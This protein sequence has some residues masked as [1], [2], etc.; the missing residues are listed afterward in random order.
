MVT[1]MSTSENFLEEYLPRATIEILPP[2][3]C[4]NFYLPDSRR[5]VTSVHQGLSQ[6]GAGEEPG[7][8]V[9][10]IVALLLRCLSATSGKKC[11]CKMR[12]YF[13]PVTLPLTIASGPTPS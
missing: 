1:E 10:K 3:P 11:F 7:Y 12:R 13:A 5:H 8:E 4:D 9:A 2:L 6:V